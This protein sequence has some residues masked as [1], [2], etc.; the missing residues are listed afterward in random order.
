MLSQGDSH[1]ELCGA[2]AE[3]IKVKMIFLMWVSAACSEREFSSW[4]KAGEWWPAGW[5][6][7]F[8]WMQLPSCTHP[9][10]RNRD[11]LG[12]QTQ[13]GRDATLQRSQKNFQ[14][15][16]WSLLWTL[17]VLQEVQRG[18]SSGRRWT[19]T[20]IKES[21]QNWERHP[22]RATWLPQFSFMINSEAL[23]WQENT[24]WE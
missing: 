12:L 5:L 21:S 20:L 1:P 13:W 4:K 22:S 8:T 9:S 19:L 24:D 11:I 2:S 16:E 14:G 23:G 15:A 3:R 18:C 7:K 17:C 10:W 6:R